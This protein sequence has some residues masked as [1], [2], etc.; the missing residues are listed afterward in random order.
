MSERTRARSLPSGVYSGIYSDPWS[1]PTPVGL[2]HMGSQVTEDFVHDWPRGRGTGDVGGPFKSVRSEVSHSTIQVDAKST[3]FGYGSWEYH[4]TVA[5]SDMGPLNGHV[6]GND[7]DDYQITSL[8]TTAIA[9]SIP[10]A[11]AADVSVMLGELFREGIPKAIGAS[12]LKNRFTDYRDIGGEYLNYQFGWKPIVSDLKSVARAITES[13]R[14]LNQLERDS[15]KNVRR[16]FKFPPHFATSES[17]GTTGAYYVAPQ[18]LPNMIVM[19][20]PVRRDYQ[21]VSRESWFSGCFTFCFERSDAQKGKLAA[22]AQKARVLLG[23]DLTPEVVWNL[24]PWSW[25]ADWATNAGDVFSNVSRF[26]RNDLAMRY[27]YMMSKGESIQTTS[28]EGVMSRDMNG[29]LTAG[30]TVS[31]TW[32]YNTKRRIPAT[33]YGFGFDMGGLSF[34]QS[35]ILGALGISRGPRV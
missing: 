12:M 35:A 13:E 16:T 14:T 19:A 22:Q 4:G 28:L 21:N 6:M 15:G 5:A 31:S 23:L 9:R 3:I 29:N 20:A 26:A 8:G 18:W 24:S 33:P 1:P 34:R 10:T 25:L 30:R 7:L 32:R 17:V 27:G 2:T 11:P